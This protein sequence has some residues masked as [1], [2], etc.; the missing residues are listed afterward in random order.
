M[1]CP[2]LWWLSCLAPA[3]LRWASAHQ[4]FQVAARPRRPL[5]R[6]PRHGRR[7]PHAGRRDEPG[8]QEG[9]AQG[10]PASPPESGFIRSPLVVLGTIAIRSTS[11]NPALERH[12]Q[13]RGCSVDPFRGE[14]LHHS[15]NPGPRP[16]PCAVSEIPW[17]G[18]TRRRLRR[19][20]RSRR[21]VRGEAAN[22]V[23]CSLG[24][25]FQTFICSFTW[26]RGPIFC[27]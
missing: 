18:S 13:L 17:E 8:G 22:T 5:L 6:H 9:G 20:S 4:V 1:L 23:W 16:P 21:R 2:G 11:K 26:S 12:F 25:Q 27:W 19:L 10:G 14:N 3:G 7:G 24:V 15:W